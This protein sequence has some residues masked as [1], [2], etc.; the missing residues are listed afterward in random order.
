MARRRMA[1]PA[2]PRSAPR[3]GSRRE[4]GI[5]PAG[6]LT[7][8]TAG[9]AASQART[10]GCAR[11]ESRNRPPTTGSP[12]ARQPQT[13]AP[14]AAWERPASP[15]PRAPPRRRSN[16][17]KTARRSTPGRRLRGS[18]LR[19][20]RRTASRCRNRPEATGTVRPAPGRPFPAS[21][22]GSAATTR[23]RGARQAREAGPRSRAPPQNPSPKR[24]STLA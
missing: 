5:D 12:A 3:P 7:R 8:R 19:V 16:A 14:K 17:D 10:A 4:A 22:I 13:R 15:R 6:G 24:S 21:A 11:W 9:A 20:S 18:P 1:A 23:C 2:G